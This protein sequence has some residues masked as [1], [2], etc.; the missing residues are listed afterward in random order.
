MKKAPVSLT[1]FFQPVA[2][3]VF[4]DGFKIVGTGQQGR[5]AP[6]AVHDKSIF[7]GAFGPEHAIALQGLEILAGQ[8]RVEGPYW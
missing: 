3:A 6:L 4:T 1:P 5:I 7:A 8:V 2:Q